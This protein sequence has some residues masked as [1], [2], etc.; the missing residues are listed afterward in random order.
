MRG[1]LP[2]KGQER[3]VARL[4]LPQNVGLRSSNP[5]LAVSGQSMGTPLCWGPLVAPASRHPW[6]QP[7]G[8][9]E[10]DESI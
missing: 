9:P 2:G 7:H 8:V 10:V 6:L 1:S 5:G 4:A 3:G